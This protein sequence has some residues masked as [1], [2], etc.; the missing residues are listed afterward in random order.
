MPLPLEGGMTVSSLRRA[1]FCLQNSVGT[2]E[3]KL[4]FKIQTLGALAQSFNIKKST[5]V[6]KCESVIMTTY[7]IL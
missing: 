6:Q 1:H 3:V 2:L 4:G 5:V 7:E